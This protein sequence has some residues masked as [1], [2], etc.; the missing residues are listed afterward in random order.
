MTLTFQAYVCTERLLGLN[1]FGLFLDFFAIV[2]HD[3]IDSALV[4]GF[5][6]SANK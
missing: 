6:C 2:K 3:L 1:Q 5:P 4:S